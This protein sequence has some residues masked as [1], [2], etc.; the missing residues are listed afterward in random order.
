MMSIKYETQ[1]QCYNLFYEHYKSSVMLTNTKDVV[2]HRLEQRIK[3]PWISIE[4]ARFG[5]NYRLVIQSMILLYETTDFAT[6]VASSGETKRLYVV[7]WN[8][9]I[10]AEL[11]D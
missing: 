10:M 2:R 4:R 5:K 3:I 6:R 1:S 11:E 7:K 8:S 9:T